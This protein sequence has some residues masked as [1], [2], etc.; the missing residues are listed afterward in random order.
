MGDVMDQWTS[1]PPGGGKRVRNARRGHGKRWLARLSD[2]DGKERS[3]AFTSKDAAQDHLVGTESRARSGLW[4]AP[5]KLTFEQ[6]AEQWLS[7]QLH[8][9][10]RVRGHRGPP[11]AVHVRCD[12]CPPD[13]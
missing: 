5:S 11:V 4:V 3:K 12:R 1:Q 7:E 2:P 10:L 9:R 6:V 13:R 8:L